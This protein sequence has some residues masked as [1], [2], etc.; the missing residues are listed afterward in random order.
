[1]KQLLGTFRFIHASIIS[2]LI[3]TVIAN[4]VCYL[5]SRKGFYDDVDSG[6]DAAAISPQAVILK[7]FSA[8]SDLACSQKCFGNNQ[9]SYKKYVASTAK[10]WL[11]KTIS[12][13]ENEDKP[14]SIILR[15]AQKK[16]PGFA[17]KLDRISI[18]PEISGSQRSCI[19]NG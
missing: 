10:C 2:T 8:V 12:L 17:R 9:C 1:M 7:Y 6:K 19:K 3:L 14:R 4:K 18:K 11:M 16:R 15:A 13:A 5:D